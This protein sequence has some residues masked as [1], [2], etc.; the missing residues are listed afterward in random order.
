[1]PA[2]LA[3]IADAAIPRRLGGRRPVGGGLDLARVLG[4]RA[5]ERVGQREHL[6]L[7]EARGCAPPMRDS[8]LMISSSRR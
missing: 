5:R 1:L 3:E 6:A 4:Q 8:W 7:A 2:L